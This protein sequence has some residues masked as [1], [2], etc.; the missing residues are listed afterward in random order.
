M[1]DQFVA[2]MYGYGASGYDTAQAH[3]DTLPGNVK[4]TGDMGAP[5]GSLMFWQGGSNGYGHVA[6]SD[7]QGGIYSTDISGAGTV[8]HVP[9]SDI[10][11]KWGMGYLGWTPPVF[12]GQSGSVGVYTGVASATPVSSTTFIGSLLSGFGM[13]AS[14]LLQRGGLIVFGAILILIGLN[15]IGKTPIKSTVK[16]IQGAKK[17]GVSTAAREVSHA[18]PSAQE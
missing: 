12:Q 6:L 13:P 15:S 17:T 14:D 4:H 8:S 5:A 7:G 2:S 9:A 10:S 1:C 16:S 11:Q 3:W 18:V